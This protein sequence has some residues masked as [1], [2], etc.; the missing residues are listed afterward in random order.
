MAVPA[1]APTPL[2][3]A[4]LAS[5]PAWAAMVPQA[6]NKQINRGI[7]CISISLMS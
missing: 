3:T 6:A 4:V 7:P 1:A 2:P 5:S